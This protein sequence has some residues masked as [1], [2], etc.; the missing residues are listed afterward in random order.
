[1]LPTHD[2][3]CPKCDKFVF[4]ALSL[5]DAFAADAPT[6][7]KVRS[8]AEGDFVSCPHCG[9]R[10]SLTRITTDAGV[11]FRPAPPADAPGR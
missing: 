2:V 1:M 6:A 3:H 8:D 5:E 11:S 10:L 4:S 7:P 9:A